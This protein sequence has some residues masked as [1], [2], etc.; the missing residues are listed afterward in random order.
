V[1]EQRPPEPVDVQHRALGERRQQVAVAP[2]DRL[3]GPGRPRT[4]RVFTLPAHRT[5]RIERVHHPAIA[6]AAHEHGPVAERP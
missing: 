6:V 2:I 3:G 1:A 4:G 5:R